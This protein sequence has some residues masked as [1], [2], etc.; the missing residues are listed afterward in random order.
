MH[1]KYIY[2]NSFFFFS[3]GPNQTISDYAE[4]E[5][6]IHIGYL[7]IYKIS[8]IWRRRESHESISTV[9]IRPQTAASDPMVPLNF[10][11]SGAS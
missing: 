9:S 2:L 11:T 1:E 7:S 3:F 6:N 8:I 5:N 4:W 10:L